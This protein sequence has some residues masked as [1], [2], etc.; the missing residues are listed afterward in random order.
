MMYRKDCIWNP[1]ACSCQNS[2]YLATII[3]D[4]VITCDKNYR[5]DKNRSNKNYCNKKYFKTLYI[6][7]AL[8]LITIALLI[9]VSIYCYLIKK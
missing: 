1:A 6:L 4:S 9:A 7:L 5:N 8:L 3:D 2:K